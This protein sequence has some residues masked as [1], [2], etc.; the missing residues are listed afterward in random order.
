MASADET[1]D[2]GQP[3]K[4]TSLLDLPCVFSSAQINSE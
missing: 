4:L 2:E 1:D 3:V